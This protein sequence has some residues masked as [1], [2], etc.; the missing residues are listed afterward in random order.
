M[1]VNQVR[2]IFIDY[3][4]QKGHQLVP[5][6]NLVPATDKSLLFTNAGMVQ[7]KD[8]I[9]G[10]ENRD[11]KMAVSAQ[12]CLRAGGKHNDLENVGFTAR[13]HTLFEMLGNFSFGEY[14]KEEAIVMAWE[15]VTER[16]LLSKDRLYVTVYA[17]DQEAYD[18]WL[19][20]V[21]MPSDR[22]IRI[23]TQD[24]FWSM[25]DTGPCGPCSEIF[26][27]LGE[28]VAGGLPGTQEADGDRFMEIWN[29][30]FMQYN[31]QE[32]GQLVELAQKAVDTGMGI[33][34]IS[35]VLQGV[36]S[37]FDIDIFQK[38]ISSLK[39]Q[40]PFQMKPVA[41]KVVADHL[42]AMVFLIADQV[43]PSNEGRGYVLRRIMRRA[44]R[45]GYQ[46]GAR[47]PFLFQFVD[48]VCQVMASA[49]DEL[50][51][52][53]KNITQIVER[54]ERLFF[55]TLD[56]G[57]QMLEAHLQEHDNI[58]GQLAFKLYDTF[59]FPLDILRDIAKERGVSVDAVGFNACMDVAREKSKQS[60]AFQDVKTL[61]M[62]NYN[63]QFLGYSKREASATI[64]DLIKEEVLVDALQEGDRGVVILDQ[65]PFYP[66]GGGQIGDFGYIEQ[67]DVRFVVDVTKKIGKTIL[68]Y[69]TLIAGAMRKNDKVYALVSEKR[70]QTQRHHSAT[71]LLHAALREVLGEHV[72]QRGSLVDD[73]KLR[74]DFAHFDPL[75][76]EQIEAIEF[77]V[78]QKIVENIPALVSEMALEDAKKIGVMALFDEK[79]ESQVRVLCFGDFSKELCGGT[80]V[81]RTGDIGVFV[82]TA[83]SSAASGVRRVEAVTGQLALHH[84][85]SYRGKIKQLSQ[86]MRVDESFIVQKSKSLLEQIKA[87]SRQVGGHFDTRQLIE[88]A[89]E[90]S[91]I[92]VVY[93][94]MDPDVR[95][96]RKLCDEVREV[97]QNVIV[98]VRSNDQSGAFIACVS[99]AIKT[100]F[101]LKS[102]LDLVGKTEGLSLRFG[103]NDLLVQ[104]KIDGESELTH[105]ALIQVLENM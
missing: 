98:F 43:Y 65:T 67:G 100:Q 45:F 92:K 8:V 85:L 88:K 49:M 101:N 51:S 75:T 84:L 42:R 105:R 91:G 17:E 48:L 5:S 12:R 35:A 13:H 11:Y 93:A 69:G 23:S 18:I 72:I 76:P 74:F 96:M 9:L 52:M 14:F 31:R 83:Q 24:N 36:K 58:D 7:F 97:A 64:L 20:V 10:N 39:T 3:F 34:R 68:H 62:Y 38:I 46:D 80:H 78:N 37:N 19:N 59:G 53:S 2:Q 40:C 47:L 82:I 95:L 73:H 55:K 16:Y 60:S 70:D 25:G 71:H 86:I 99:S 61:K 57:C 21:G 77:L 33:E 63:T 30:V 89:Q 41:L 29:L 102:I 90:I 66:E 87:Q 22:I 50:P 44:M 4:V 27:D 94:D 6:S 103:G 28:D 104:G 79:Y 15:L 81:S 26:Y 56:Q 54:E 32:N 1:N